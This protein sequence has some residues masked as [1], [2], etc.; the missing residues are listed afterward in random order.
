MTLETKKRRGGF[1]LVE[2]LVVIAIIGILI[3]MLLPAV[4][5]VREAARR[6]TCGNQ[7]RQTALAVLN[8]ESSH[9][10][11]P[12]G[13][14]INPLRAPNFQLEPTPGGLQPLGFESNG[15]FW[16]WMTRIA[17]FIELNNVH[18]QIDFQAWPW[19][20]YLAD[21]STI[22]GVVA[23]TFIC[24]SESR[25][26]ETW[27]DGQGNEAA[28]TS[29]L[30][31]RGRDS[32]KE[33]GGQDGLI[34]CNSG[35]TLGAIGD[36]TSNTLMIGE[37]LASADLEYGWQWAGAGD[38][39]LGEADV[40]LGVHE[41]I[42]VTSNPESTETDFF[43]QGQV[44]DPDN[45]HRFHFWSNHPGGGMWALADGS[46]HFYSYT[47]DSGNNGSNGSAPTVLEQLATRDGQEVVSPIQ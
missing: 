9:M 26:D 12:A 36:G 7:I 39:G 22:N 44:E 19:W 47:I 45:L 40:V 33:S 24:P 27:D 28:V 32:Y 1:T 14:E 15:P 5:Q 6:I 43:R 41:R 34:Y 42:A 20:Q 13:H 18:D 30:G 4:Q 29:Y 46:V 23:P 3:G 10:D 35:T 38:N 17:P 25:G 16:S 8:Y 2:L 21:G 37:R 11:L 31:V